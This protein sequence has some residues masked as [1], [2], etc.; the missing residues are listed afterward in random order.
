M[1]IPCL[2]GGAGG[3]GVPGAIMV[4]VRSQRAGVF[5]APPTA[6]P[7]LLYLASGVR[8]WSRAADK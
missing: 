8:D 7:V 4:T 2:L 1:A 5:R 6:S 3:V